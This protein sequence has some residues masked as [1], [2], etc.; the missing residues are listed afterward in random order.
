MAR[1]MKGWWLGRLKGRVGAFKRIARALKLFFPMTRDVVSGRYRPVPWSA[2]GMMALALGYLIMPFDL[3]PDFLFLIGVVDDALIIG[4]LLDRIDRRL[5]GY[6]AW[7][8]GDPE[9]LDT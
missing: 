3:I 6:R 8:Y 4:W 7:K 5:I 9:P 1:W 2:F